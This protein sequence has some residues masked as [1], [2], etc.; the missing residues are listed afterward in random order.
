[1]IDL[2]KDEELTKRG[3]IEKCNKKVWPIAMSELDLK[4]DLDVKVI[5]DSEKSI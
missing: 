1:M 4:E 2:K 5:R 3:N